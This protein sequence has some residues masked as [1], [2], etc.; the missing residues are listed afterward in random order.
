MIA[1]HLK[2]PWCGES[3]PIMGPGQ[4]WMHPLRCAQKPLKIGESLPPG[5]LL[6]PGPAGDAAWDELDA[7]I[8]A[9]NR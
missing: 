5:D 3:T 2:C 6:D 4:I 7:R 1:D 8:A 9:G